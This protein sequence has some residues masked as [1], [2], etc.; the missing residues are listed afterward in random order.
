M[1]F[2]QIEF[3]VSWFEFK[4]GE[5]SKCLIRIVKGSA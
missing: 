1:R 4:V 5:A 3:R 2:T